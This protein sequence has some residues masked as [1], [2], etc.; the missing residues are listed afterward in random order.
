MLPALHLM[1]TFGDCTLEGRHSLPR[2]ALKLVFKA[3]SRLKHQ[4]QQIEVMAV[5]SIAQRGY[6]VSLANASGLRLT[7][8]IG[9]TYL[10]QLCSLAV[11][12]VYDGNPKVGQIGLRTEQ[13]LL[14]YLHENGASSG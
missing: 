14:L 9:K 8:T 5:D 12:I 11:L 3:P 7:L 1:V 4:V 13:R 6:G 2:A 10:N